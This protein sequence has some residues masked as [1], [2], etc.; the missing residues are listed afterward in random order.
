VTRR[1]IRRVLACGTLLVGLSMLPASVWSAPATRPAEPAAANEP[2]AVTSVDRGT[3]VNGH[4]SFG[5]VPLRAGRDREAAKAAA[6]PTRPESTTGLEYSRVLTALAVVVGLIFVLRWAARAIFKLPGSRGSIRGVR[7]L[8]RT[9]ISP[10]QQVMLLQVGRRIVVVGDCAGQMH[11]LAEI[12]EPDEVASL[13]GQVGPEPAEPKAF[14][15]LFTR[16]RRSFDEPPPAPPALVDEEDDD[17][18]VTSAREEISGLMQK[19][20]LMA[21]QFKGT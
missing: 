6:A 12:T 5:D 15:N 17:P 7:V 16:S 14:G 1:R 19:V 9:V 10:K 20:R 21:S 4:E 8:G 13:L 3:D 11:P 18:E 2:P